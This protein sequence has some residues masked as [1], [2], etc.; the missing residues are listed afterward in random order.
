MKKKN[1]SSLLVLALAATAM[2]ACGGGGGGAGGPDAV[3]PSGE[4]IITGTGETVNKAAAL[5]RAIDL[6]ESAFGRS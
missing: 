2:A 1:Q 5:G 4:K 3:D 6:A